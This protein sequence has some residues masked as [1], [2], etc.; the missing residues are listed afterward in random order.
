MKKLINASLVSIL[1]VLLML[2]TS[3]M[4]ATSVFAHSGNTDNN[5]GHF[6]KTTTKQVTYTNVVYNL[7]FR[8]NIELRLNGVL[9]TKGETRVFSDIP[10]NYEIKTYLFKNPNG[11]PMYSSLVVT[12][13]LVNGTNTILYQLPNNSPQLTF[14]IDMNF[15]VQNYHY[16]SGIYAGKTINLL[17]KNIKWDDRFKYKGSLIPLDTV[18]TAP[19]TAAPT[20]EPTAEPTIAPTT[21]EGIVTPV[22]TNL[23]IK[24]L[25]KTGEDSSVMYVAIGF[26]IVLAG[27]AVMYWKKE[28]M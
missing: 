4:L 19:T 16:H 7:G 8:P 2:V 25:P 26:V 10:V 23:I 22:S 24:T 18:T 5:G 1:L 14:T 15:M 12:G 9:I 13:T 27:L 21:E 3:V 17:D 11:T 20:T 28:K 6:Q